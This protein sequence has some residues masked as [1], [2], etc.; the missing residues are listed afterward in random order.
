MVGVRR[1]DDHGE[2]AGT[3]ADHGPEPE[4]Q[5]GSTPEPES[6]L[7]VAAVAVTAAVSGGWGR[8]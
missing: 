4:R 7:A 3:E 1:P 2:E 8:V 5:L 6:G